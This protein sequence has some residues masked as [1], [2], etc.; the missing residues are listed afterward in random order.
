MKKRRFYAFLSAASLSLGGVIYILFRPATYIAK[1][2]IKVFPFIS[3]I[4]GVLFLSNCTFLKYYFPDYLWAFSLLCCFNAVSKST[5]T[6]VYRA[7]AVF[8]MGA[9]WEIL[10]YFHIISGTGDLIDVFMYITA[11]LSVVLLDDIYGRI[12]SS[13]KIKLKGVKK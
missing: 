5:K 3:K 7:C 6:M 8:L 2:F 9:L 1:A 4:S 10:Q 12:I 13:E 11:V